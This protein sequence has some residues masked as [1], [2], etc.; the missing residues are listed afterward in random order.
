MIKVILERDGEEAY[1]IE[2]SQAD[3]QLG[4][5]LGQLVCMVSSMHVGGASDIVQA[6]DMMT[7]DVQADE[8]GADNG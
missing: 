8:A 2:L 1:R 7:S 3:A 5:L 4:T 6:I